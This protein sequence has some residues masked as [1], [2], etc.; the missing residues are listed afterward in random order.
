M[1]NE[2][3]DERE[4]QV[5]DLYPVEPRRDVPW[6][7]RQAQVVQTFTETAGE[8]YGAPPGRHGRAD[9]ASP[10]LQVIAANVVAISRAVLLLALNVAG[11]AVTLSLLVRVLEWLS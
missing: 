1:N 6:R 3:D 2:Y 10:R 9:D 8:P 7:V 11:A 4:H 5:F